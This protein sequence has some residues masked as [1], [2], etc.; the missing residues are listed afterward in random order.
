MVL[1]AA[2]VPS[3]QSDE[4][5]AWVPPPLMAVARALVPFV[6]YEAYKP[7][8]RV[9][10]MVDDGFSELNTL[11]LYVMGTLK[12][13]SRQ[14]QYGAAA[15]QAHE[16]RINEFIERLPDDLRPARDIQD[17]PVVWETRFLVVDD[18]Q[19]LRDLFSRL[20]CRL[21]DVETAENGADAL[22][23]TEKTF[24]NVIITDVNMPVMDGLE[25]YRRAVRDDPDAR[26]QFIFYTG[27]LAAEAAA[28]LQAN[29]L[30]YL[31]KPFTLDAITEMIDRALHTF[32]EPSR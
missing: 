3:L 15:V 8:A 23:K 1:A 5:S 28:F 31:I 32:P 2:G 17:L 7:L 25:F 12:A 14:F 13:H 21:G 18:E 16:R 27:A 20:L 29:R 4:P 24:Y 19:C 11:F 22:A 26:A 6:L 30:P 10:V 9:E